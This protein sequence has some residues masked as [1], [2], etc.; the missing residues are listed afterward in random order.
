MTIGIADTTVVIHLYRRY[1]PALAW[2]GSLS[3]A[4]SITPITW[5]EV[6]YGAGSKV[7]LAD[8]LVILG[9]FDMLH[10]TSRDQDWAVEQMKQYRL[11]HGVAAG[12]CFIASVAYR[13]QLP[14]Y[15]HNLK[16]MAP[17]IG[18]LAIKPYS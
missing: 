9:Q 8:Y 14:L 5:M 6:L 10:L 13:L 12:D 3:Q 2:Y 18:S 16:D 15:T 7:K 11:S 1:P 17:L 4:L